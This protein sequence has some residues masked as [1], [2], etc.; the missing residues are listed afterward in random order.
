MQV[1]ERK[2][3]VEVKGVTLIVDRVGL[4]PDAP[5]IRGLKHVNEL[6]DSI[7]NGF[8]AL[9]VF[10]VQCK[11]IDYFT[12]HRVMQKEFGDALDEAAKVGV[13]MLCLD[14]DVKE[15]SILASEIKEVKL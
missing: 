10:I 12:P 2:V 11:G 3:F 13:K 6:I 1:G 4:F 8:E 9:I 5:T 14:C 7:E 15:N